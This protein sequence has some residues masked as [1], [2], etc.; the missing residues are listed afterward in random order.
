MQHKDIENLATILNNS[1]CYRVTRKYQ[2]PE[3]YNHGDEDDKM[4]AVFLDIEATGLSYTQD[5]LIELG[6]VKF[7]YNKYGSIFRLLDD[8]SGYQDAGKP[9][10]EHITKLTG[11]A[12]DTVRE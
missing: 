9:I 3:Y 6:M 4:I 8:F 2:R 7:E 11:I 5:K 1:G 10:P 12:D